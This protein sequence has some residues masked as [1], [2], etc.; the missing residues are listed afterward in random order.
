MWGFRFNIVAIDDKRPDKSRQTVLPFAGTPATHCLARWQIIP[1]RL[2]PIF[3]ISSPALRQLSPIELMKTC[4]A[5]FSRYGRWSVTQLLPSR[6]FT[7]SFRHIFIVMVG[8]ISGSHSPGTTSNNTDRKFQPLLWR[9]IEKSIFNTG[10]LYPISLIH[11]NNI[12]KFSSSRCW[13][14]NNHKKM[15]IWQ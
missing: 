14:V 8:N 12:Y 15:M 11:D 10:L 5:K 6:T 13:S 1:G 2:C 7:V 4:A 9:I 3:S